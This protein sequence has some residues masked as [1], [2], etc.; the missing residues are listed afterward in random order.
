[1]LIYVQSP[2]F[3]TA[4]ADSKGEQGFFQLAVGTEWLS[5]N[6][7]IMPPKRTYEAE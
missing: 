1:M 7:I 6:R 2:M 4:F 5:H 3:E